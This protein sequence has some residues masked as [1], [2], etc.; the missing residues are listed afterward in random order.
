MY[1]WSLLHSWIKRVP[2]GPLLF[3]LSRPLHKLVV[4]VVLHEGPRAGAATLS[5]VEKE[6][7]VTLFHGMVH[8]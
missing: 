1:L 7:E 8:C 5:H 6:G 3:P 4:D 2:N